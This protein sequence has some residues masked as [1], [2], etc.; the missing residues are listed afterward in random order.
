M[1][2]TLVLNINIVSGLELFL[3]N[4]IRG[5]VSLSKMFGFSL[6]LWP[7]FLFSTRRYVGGWLDTVLKWSYEVIT[8]RDYCDHVTRTGIYVTLL[9]MTWS[10]VTIVTTI[11][12][13][14]DLRSDRTHISITLLH[15]WV[16]SSEVY[17]HPGHPVFNV[18]ITRC[19][20]R[21][22]HHSLPL[23]TT[24]SLL[25]TQSHIPHNIGFLTRKE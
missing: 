20:V 13:C 16:R 19:L 17:S 8:A 21:T 22:F 14:L 12:L 24:H 25:C 4:D 18:T 10:H 3:P 2:W 9:D 1:C 15:V 11:N 6:E 7:V 5:Y 23:Y